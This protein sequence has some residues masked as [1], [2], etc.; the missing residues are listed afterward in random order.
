[1][2][3]CA[4]Y[5]TVLVTG[6]SVHGCPLNALVKRTINTTDIVVVTPQKITTVIRELFVVWSKVEVM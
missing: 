2:I 4:T 3:T 1:M 6:E 5:V